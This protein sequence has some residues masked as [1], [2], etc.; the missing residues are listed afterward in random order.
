MWGRT[1]A[2]ANIAAAPLRLHCTVPQ[3]EERKG[4][5]DAFQDDQLSRIFAALGH[6]G[7]QASWP[8]VEVLRHWREN[9]G[10]CRDPRPE[11]GSI[12]LKQ[13][14]WENSPLL[15]CARCCGASGWGAG[16]TCCSLHSVGRCLLQPADPWNARY[17]P[18]PPGHCCS[19]FPKPEALLDL[20]LGMLCLD[21]AQRL[22][23]A[24]ALQH[25]WFQQ[26]GGLG[27]GRAMCGRGQSLGA[28]HSQPP[29]PACWLA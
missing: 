29:T 1:H 10:G 17:H 11:H 2:L 20:L 24:A 13:L 8:G 19:A 15:R 16:G 14:L 6:P 12:N 28:A 27:G 26:V 3:G 9:T 23:A 18:P 22:T 7:S 25:D 4:A 5:P 21:P